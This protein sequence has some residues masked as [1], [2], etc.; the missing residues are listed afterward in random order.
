[1]RVDLWLKCVSFTYFFYYR[2]TSAN[3]LTV[4]VLMGK[5]L[6]VDWLLILS[7]KK[8]EFYLDNHIC[9]CI[10]IYSNFLMMQW[11]ISESLV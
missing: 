10:Y 1:M 6:L 5:L 2:Q 3:A 11:I 8:M 4:E 7:L 9:V